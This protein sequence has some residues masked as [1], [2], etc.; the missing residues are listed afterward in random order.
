MG[1]SA[2]FLLIPLSLG[3]ISLEQLIQE[4]LAHNPALQAQGKLVEAKEA[5]RKALRAK[6][7]GSVELIGSYTRYNTPRPL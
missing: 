4:A 5:R 7:R 3:A 1:W 2:L 6:K